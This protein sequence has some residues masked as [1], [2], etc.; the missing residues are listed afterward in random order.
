M[1]ALTLADLPPPPSGRAGWPWAEDGSLLPDTLPNGSPWPRVSVVT[2]SYNQAQFIEETI[3]SALLQGYPNLEYIIVDGGSTDGSVEIIRRYADHLAWW[4]SEPDSGQSEAIN[5]GFA[6]ATGDIL[7]WLNSDDVYL[8]GAM[9]ASVAHLTAHPEVNLV[10]GDAQIIDETGNRVGGIAGAR[11]DLKRLVTDIH[12]IPQPTAFWRR[13]TTTRLGPLRTDLHYV[14]DWEWWLRVARSGGGLT[15]LPG[16]R[17][18][19]RVHTASKTG[20]QW[21]RFFGE[22]RQVLEAFFA[23]PDLPVEYCAW[24]RTAYSNEAI[25]TARS[26]LDAG[27]RKAA[28]PKLWEGLRLAP[29][30]PRSGLVLLMMLDAATGLDTWGWVTSLKRRLKG[31]RG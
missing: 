23:Q 13:E 20:S 24:A 27:E 6:R 4:V 17:A 14:M 5:K 16:E 25:Y 18:Q 12:P 31:K 1:R 28:L 7:A 15:H 29:W 19:F 8:P 22:R 3:R 26:L 2:P 30:R 9:A 11:F 10:Y 21:L